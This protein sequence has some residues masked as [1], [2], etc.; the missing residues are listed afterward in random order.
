MVGTSAWALS[1]LPHNH[2]LAWK[3]PVLGAW[4]LVLGAF[5]PAL[6]F[7]EMHLVVL[8]SALGLGAGL[9]R[10]DLGNP[11]SAP[12][13]FL[14]RSRLGSIDHDGRTADPTCPLR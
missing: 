5:A 7:F 12:A 14:K 1:M 11:D 13:C 3:W 10:T 2:L 4:C 9:G 6:I 8:Q